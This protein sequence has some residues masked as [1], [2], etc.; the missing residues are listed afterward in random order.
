V[1]AGA[2]S[3]SKADGAAAFVRT[4]SERNVLGSRGGIVLPITAPT[5]RFSFLERF[6]VS[7]V[8][9]PRGELQRAPWPR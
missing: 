2:G 4:G 5:A 6:K 1:P 3:G 9:G 7:P 8:P